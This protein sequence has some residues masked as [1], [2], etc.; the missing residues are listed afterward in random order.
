MERDESRMKSDG[1][2]SETKMPVHLVES[3][4]ATREAAERSEQRRIKPNKA[5]R[6]RKSENNAI[7][8]S[9]HCAEWLRPICKQVSR[10]ILC[11]WASTGNVTR[12]GGD[13]H[14]LTAKMARFV[15][16]PRRGQKVR[17]SV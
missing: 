5:S 10:Q 13:V 6:S 1:G 16:P 7:N 9:N 11:A 2:S 3:L 14:H 4:T 17:R 15:R 8:I 12:P